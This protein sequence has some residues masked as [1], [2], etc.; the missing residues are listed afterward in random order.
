M[1]LVVYFVCLFILVFS[2]QK[3]SFLA[4]NLPCFLGIFSSINITTICTA[5]RKEKDQNHHRK[6]KSRQQAAAA[7]SIQA[8]LLLVKTM[9][10]IW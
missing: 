10:S 5:A 2:L 1:A 4:Y 3:Y 8:G 9:K 7:T 6:V